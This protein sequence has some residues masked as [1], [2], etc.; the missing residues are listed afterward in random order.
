MLRFVKHVRPPVKSATCG[1]RTRGGVEPV[2]SRIPER[3]T[4]TT[5]TEKGSIARSSTALVGQLGL[6][7]GLELPADTRSGRER[8]CFFVA[9]P[10]WPSLGILTFLTKPNG[11]RKN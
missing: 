3:R 8:R 10:T 1:H 5:D 9:R 2:D 4:T 11:T 6:G 7:V